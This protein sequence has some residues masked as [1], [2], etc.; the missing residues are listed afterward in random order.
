MNQYETIVKYIPNEESADAQWIEWHKMLSRAFGREKANE[1]FTVAFAYSASSSAK[2]N[3]LRDY[4][5]TVGLDLDT[6]LLQD[7]TRIISSVKEGVGGFFDSIGRGIKMYRNALIV[8]VILILA[9]VFI[10]LFNIAK[11]PSEAIGA[12][13]KGFA[14]SK[15]GV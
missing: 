15:G 14:A 10:L 7:A 12:A 4:G 1:A 13:S 2:T 6:N 8:V 9:P 11:N 3:K 5:K